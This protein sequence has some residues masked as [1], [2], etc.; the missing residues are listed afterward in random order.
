M[1]QTNEILSREKFDEYIDEAAKAAGY[2]SFGLRGCDLSLT[3]WWAAYTRQSL[4]EQAD[5]NRIPEYLLTCARMA[6]EQKLIVPR[7]YIIVDHESSEY[8]DRKYMASLRK[9][10][11]AKRRI[12]G[13]IIPSQGRLTMDAG[14]QLFFEK[15]CSYYEVSLLFGDAPSGSDWP[16]QTSRIIMAQANALRVKTNRDNARAGS[17]GRVLKHMVPACRAPYGYRYMA[18]RDKGRGGKLIVKKAW[19]DINEQG[20]EG[21]SIGKSPA[22]VVLQIFTWIGDEGRTLHWVANK[23][24]EMG[25]EAPD[26]GKWSPAIISRIV[27][28]SCY[29]GKHYYNVFARVPNPDRPLGDYTAEIKRTLVRPKP[30]NQ[31]VEFKVPALISEELWQKAVDATTKR[32]RGRG[33]QGKKLQALLRSRVFCPKCGKPMVVRRAGRRNHVYYHCSKYYRRWENNPCDYR[34]FVPG[35]WENEVW[36]D[37]CSWLRDD[38][39]VEQQLRSEQIQ[40]DNIEK[41]IR[42]QESKIAQAKGKIDRIKV[43]FEGG[44]YSL[45]DAKK[46]I[47]GYQ[48]TTSKAEEEIGRLRREMGIQ[49]PFVDTHAMKRG[50][51]ALRDRNLDN[52]TFEE[53]LDIVSKLGIKVYPSEDLKSVHVS[54]QLNLELGEPDGHGNRQGLIKPQADG[55]SEGVN[56]CVKVMNGTPGGTRTRAPGSGGQCSIL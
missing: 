2:E 44:L 31:W 28:H 22:W 45:E 23:L 3:H 53:K 6:K 41:L 19:W 40:G 25:I 43:G 13:V 49:A 37:I 56:Q 18:E 54:C 50:L 36:S 20:P 51:Q 10:L 14:Q 52:A 1:D 17:I 39:W 26:G 11:I 42:L 34:G 21:T 4:E 16:S 55:G 29:T 48:A 38:A 46:R 9:E 24:N 47:E 12:Q 8:L 35:A 27:R 32:G 5:N 33:K 30:E 7:E 15:E